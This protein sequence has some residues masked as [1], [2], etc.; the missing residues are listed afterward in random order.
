M[1]I[2]AAACASSCELPVRLPR[3]H[4]QQMVSMASDTAKTLVDT[5]A[6]PS[7]ACAAAI[8]PSGRVHPVAGDTQPDKAAARSASIPRGAPEEACHSQQEWQNVGRGSFLF[9]IHALLQL[10]LEEVDV[11]VPFRFRT[12]PGHCQATKLTTVIVQQWQQRVD[13]QALLPTLVKVFSSLLPTLVKD[14][15]RF[16]SMRQRHSRL[17]GVALN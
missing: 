8:W 7:Q 1:T 16:F 14:R 12:V 17:F 10:L 6:Q 5:D 9:A 4:K 3:L 15:C 2:P 11:V 13:F